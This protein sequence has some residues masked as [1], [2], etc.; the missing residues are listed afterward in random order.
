VWGEGFGVQGL[1]FRVKDLDCKVQCLV[2]RVVFR[3]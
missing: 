2:F 1:V 3:V